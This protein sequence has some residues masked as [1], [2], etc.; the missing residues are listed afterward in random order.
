MVVLFTTTMT[1]LKT[2]FLSN[3]EATL[4][5]I[6]AANLLELDGPIHGFVMTR[7]DFISIVILMELVNWYHNL[8]HADIRRIMET[9]D[10]EDDYWLIDNSSEPHFYIMC[11]NSCKMT[12]NDT[13]DPYPYE[14]Q[15]VAISENLP[16]DIW[17]YDHKNVGFVEDSI[18]FYKIIKDTYCEYIL[19]SVHHDDKKPSYCDD[20]IL[21]AVDTTSG[22][23]YKRETTI[24]NCKPRIV[25]MS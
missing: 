19:F 6:I 20:M 17:G 3:T 14:Y 15:L 4:K 22:K 10:R 1:T 11:P 18:D 2:Q 8:T 25:R 16:L 21:S 5:N 9:G 12:D 7:K 13:M 23:I 24:H